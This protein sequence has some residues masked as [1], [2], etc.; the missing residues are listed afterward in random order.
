MKKQKFLKGALLLTTLSVIAFNVY[1]VAS[2]KA[3][4][5]NIG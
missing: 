4:K 1:F 3:S 5:L 2:K